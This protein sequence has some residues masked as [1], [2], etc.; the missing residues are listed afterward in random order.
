MEQSEKSDEEL[1]R[2]IA[3]KNEKAFNELY[4]RYIGMVFSVAKDYFPIEAEDI[5]QKVFINIHKKAGLYSNNG[6]VS[7]WIYSIAKNS[8][9]SHVRKRWNQTLLESQSDGLGYLI[10]NLPSELEN[11]WRYLDTKECFDSFGSGLEELS[12][13]QREVSLCSFIGFS[14]K[15]IAKKMNVSVGTVKSRKNRAREKLKEKMKEYI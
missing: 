5:A 15:D 14:E 6:K 4:K 7:N 2:E 3:E 11:P 12:S 8:S 1:L 9:I 13:D 10:D